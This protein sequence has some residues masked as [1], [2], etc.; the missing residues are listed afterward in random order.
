MSPANQPDRSFF[1]C[2]VSYHSIPFA[3]RSNPISERLVALAAESREP[4]Q[5]EAFAAALRDVFARY[6]QAGKVVIQYETSVYLGQ[7]L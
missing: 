1:C 5:A 3:G 4:E 2:V 7:R 6:Q